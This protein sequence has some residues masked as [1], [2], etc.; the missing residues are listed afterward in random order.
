MKKCIE[1]VLH[2]L[3][4]VF[5]QLLGISISSFTDLCI[6]KILAFCEIY[7]SCIC[8]WSLFNNNNL[9]L[10][11]VVIMISLYY[12][13]I[14]IFLHFF[15]YSKVP[16]QGQSYWKF[17]NMSLFYFCP[18]Y[19]SIKCHLV[20]SFF[21]FLCGEM[22][23]SVCLEPEA[24]NGMWSFSNTATLVLRRTHKEFY[25]YLFVR[26]AFRS[27]G[28]KDAIEILILIFSLHWEA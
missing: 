18:S 12:F 10:L 14:S 7:W 16:F 11:F 26:N 8:L 5:K 15:Y 3:T 6:P 13:L 19:L 9:M 20:F 28:Q 25:E 27:G 2:S 17:H 24:S 23:V 22:I 21:L 1:F 4:K